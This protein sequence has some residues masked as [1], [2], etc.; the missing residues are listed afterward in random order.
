MP[1]DQGVVGEHI[2]SHVAFAAGLRVFHRPLAHAPNLEAV[3]FGKDIY[4]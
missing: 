2:Q 1:E 4:S 3:G